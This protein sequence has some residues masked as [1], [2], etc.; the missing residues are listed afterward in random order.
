M[1]WQLGSLWRAGIRLH[2]VLVDA[3]QVSAVEQVPDT[4]LLADR[5]QQPHRVAELEAKLFFFS[6]DGGQFTEEIMGLSLLDN[7]SQ[8]VGAI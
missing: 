6:T 7:Q 5:L 3:L 2:R 8:L 1:L 4:R